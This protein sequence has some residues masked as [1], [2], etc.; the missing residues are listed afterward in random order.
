MGAY[1]RSTR[2]KKGKRKKRSYR[3]IKFGENLNFVS[4]G[5]EGKKKTC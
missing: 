3:P 4:L 1:R 5:K 2:K